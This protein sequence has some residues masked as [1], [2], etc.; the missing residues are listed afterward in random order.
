MA[1]SPF[2]HPAWIEID[3]V[4]FKK[5]IQAIKAYI[6]EVKFCLPIKANAYGHG[7][8]PIA[9]AAVAAGVDYLGV[10]CLQ[11]GALLRQSGIRIPILVFG[12]IHQE[13]I[14]ELIEYDLEFSIASCLKAKMVLEICEALKKN[15]KVHLEIDT[16]MQRTGVRIETAK[17]LLKFL[18]SHSH[19]E[20]VGI[21]SHFANADIP[22][23]P[24]TQ[25]QIHQFKAFV[26]EFIGSPQK[27]ILCHLANSGG[28]VHFRD[29]YF[30]MVRPGLLAFGQYEPL[31]GS[32]QAI[33][34]CFQ[35]K[36][37][38][39]YFKVVPKGAGIGYGHR[40]ITRDNTRIIT[41]PLG[42]GDGLRRALSNKG[43]I[44]LNGQRYPIVG[45]ICMDQFMVNIGEHSG[46][47]GDVVTIIGAQNS[48]AI[49][50]GEMAS[51]CDTIS[52]EILCGFNNRLPRLYHMAHTSQWESDFKF[53][54]FAQ[55]SQK[56][57]DLTYTL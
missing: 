18:A 22:D 55:C 15:V 14:P 38:I 48:E 13:Q 54:Q 21:Y 45:S 44:L 36:A 47:V 1:Q 2:G 19:F 43:A 32:L 28:V 5:N 9:H 33:R 51:L 30:D 27:K 26:E 3:L 56:V 34:S 11:E 8:L 17:D 49:T 50:V 37:K 25:R 20:V 4:Q 42:Y 29:S 40:Y 6:G 35:V 52:Y 23:N 7:L 57:N 41:I 39:A 24:F 16:G 46:Y 12:A 31:F 53:S 10:S